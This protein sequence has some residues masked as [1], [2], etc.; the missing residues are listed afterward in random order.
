MRYGDEKKMKRAMGDVTEMT[1]SVVD[2]E[3]KAMAATKAPPAVEDEDEGEGME[4]GETALTPEE[5]ET[6][7]AL[8]AKM[9]G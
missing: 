8:L 2:D 9:K 3:L 1:D 7:Q 4:S 5:M 6:L